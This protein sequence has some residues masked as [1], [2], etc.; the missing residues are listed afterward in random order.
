MVDLLPRLNDTEVMEPEALFSEA[1]HRTRRRP[2]LI[3]GGAALLT[4]SLA[5]GIM[6][7]TSGNGRSAT[8]P[9]PGFASGHLSEIES[10]ASNIA[11]AYSRA[12]VK[13]ALIYSTTRKKAFDAGTGMDPSP[14]NQRCYVLVFKGHFGSN[15]SPFGA[16]PPSGKYLIISMNPPGESPDGGALGIVNTPP[17]PGMGRSYILLPK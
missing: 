5:I 3:G 2:L 8:P 12:P 17:G 4:A 16:V 13:T 7:G 14:A 10:Y 1:K 6:L 15:R 9:P 11:R